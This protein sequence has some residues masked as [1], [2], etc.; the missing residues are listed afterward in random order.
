MTTTSS[1]QLLRGAARIG[2]VIATAAILLVGW[3][4]FSRIEARAALAADAQSEA[5]LPVLVT[6]VSVGSGSDELIL[7]GSLQAF[8]ETPIYARTSGYLKRWLVDIGTPVKAGQLL[9][10]IDTPEIDQET[11]QA[12]ADL[13]TAE[14]NNRLAQLTATRWQ[15]LLATDSVSKQDNDDKAGDAAA[16]QAAVASARANLQRLRELEGFKRI[17]SPVDGVVTARNT[18]VGDLID[19]GSTNARELFHVAVT[20][21]LRVYVQVPES[22]AEDMH[23]GD[24]AELRAREHPAATFKA[25][26]VSTASAIDVTTHTLLVQLDVDNSSSQLLPGGYVEVHFN[27]ARHADTLRVP[28]NTLIFGANGMQVAVVGPDNRIVMQTIT[29]GRDFGKEVEVL[30][31]LKPDQSIVLNPPDS[32]TAGLSVTPQAAA[33]GN[34]P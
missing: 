18:D 27:L 16:K 25:S 13:Q 31:G 9:A 15:G 2:I 28:A 33:G 14:A 1:P 26:L 23:A 12:E 24:T 19:A 30:A 4:I 8:T 17:V 6:R 29:P 21:H 11:A 22:Y 20:K 7:P 10:E 32:I 5:A 34:K 3:G